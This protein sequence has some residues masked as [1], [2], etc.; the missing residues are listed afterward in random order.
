M[1][2]PAV[3]STSKSALIG[4]TRYLATYLGELILDQTQLVQ[5]V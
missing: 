3:Y 1:S 4:L 2:T 5:E